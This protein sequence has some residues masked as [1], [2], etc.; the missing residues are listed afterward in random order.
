MKPEI[1]LTSIPNESS[2]YQE[3]Q[4]HWNTKLHYLSGLASSDD[5]FVLVSFRFLLIVEMEWAVLCLLSI[6]VLLVI[7]NRLQIQFHVIRVFE[8]KGRQ[9]WVKRTRG[10]R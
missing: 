6:F 8:T 9:S 4:Y 7:K 5:D 2:F 3:D 1:G 10:I